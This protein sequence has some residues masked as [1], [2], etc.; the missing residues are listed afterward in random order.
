MKHED[1]ISE[2]QLN[3][4]IDGELDSEDRARILEA[5]Q[6]DAV[7]KAS[8]CEMRTIQELVRHAYGSPDIQETRRCAPTMSGWGKGLAASLLLTS[9]A[10]LGWFGHGQTAESRLQAMYW[11]EQNS[12]Q[13]ASIGQAAEKPGSKKVLVHLNTSD[14]NKVKE[15]LD[16]AEELLRTYAQTN[17]PAEMEIVANAGGLDLLRVGHSPYAERVRDLQNQY[18]NLHFLACQTAMDRIKHE[19]GIDISNELLPGV[20]ITPSAL[21]QILDRLR[22]GWVYIKV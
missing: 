17:Q 6:G 19:Q 8:A 4:F 20:G 14:L 16:T 22:E 10:L 18:L 7:L 1:T 12:F 2:E 3:A 13:N 11:N 9:G 5:I 21:D 15:A